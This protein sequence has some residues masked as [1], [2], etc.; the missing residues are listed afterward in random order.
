MRKSK[1][2]NEIAEIIMDSIT[3][4]GIKSEICQLSHINGRD[5]NVGK[6]SQMKIPMLTFVVCALYTLLTERERA[7]VGQRFYD[8][9]K[10]NAEQFED[11]QFLGGRS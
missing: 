1:M 5:L 3:E 10:R 9:F 7:R 11:E 4:K 8:A 2:A 6:L